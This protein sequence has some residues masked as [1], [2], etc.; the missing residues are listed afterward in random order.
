MVSY[1]WFYAE[2]NKNAFFEKMNAKIN[3]EDKLITGTTKLSPRSVIYFLILW[4]DF[5]AEFEQELSP[6]GH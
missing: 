3:D 1:T 6:I 2:H 5:L 4:E